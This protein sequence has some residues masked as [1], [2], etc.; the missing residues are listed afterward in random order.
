MWNESITAEKKIWKVKKADGRKVND[1]ADP[2]KL[3]EA[4]PVVR[5]TEKHSD[6]PNQTFQNLGSCQLHLTLEMWVKFS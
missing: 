2:R 1:L 5:E 4:K 6:L 3:N